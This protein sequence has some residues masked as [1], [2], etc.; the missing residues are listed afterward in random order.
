MKKSVL[1]IFL[2][3]IS[4]GLARADTL[5]DMLDSLDESVVIYFAVFILSFVIFFFALNKFFKGNR[6]T[7]GVVSGVLS[8]LIIY[9]INKTGF[10]VG[11]FF[12]DL[13]VAAETLSL[14]VSLIVLAGIILVIIKLKNNSLFVFGGLLLVGSMFVYAKAILIIIGIVLILARLTVFKGKKDSGSGYI[15]G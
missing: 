6:A 1:S 13:G 8:F 15:K 4:I 3:L 5:S 11:D 10:S 7:A 2:L 9:G 12:L 14:I